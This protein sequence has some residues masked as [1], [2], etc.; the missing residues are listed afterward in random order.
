MKLIFW[1]VNSKMFDDI[2][3]L[4]NELESMN[5]NI[6]YICDM[7]DVL[8]NL[9]GVVAMA[10]NPEGTKLVLADLQAKYKGK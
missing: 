1:S 3:K 6:Q 8:V 9:H 5:K 4:K 7:M 2:A 10:H